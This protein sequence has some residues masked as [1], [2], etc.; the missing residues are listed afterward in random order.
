[1]GRRPSVTGE[2]LRKAEFRGK[3]VTQKNRGVN[4]HVLCDLRLQTG[5]GG[6]SG[7]LWRGG[8]KHFHH[9]KFCLS[10]GS[11]RPI[12]GR[13]VELGMVI[14]DTGGSLL[15][16]EE[17]QR[18]VYDHARVGCDVHVPAAT[19]RLGCRCEN[20]KKGKQL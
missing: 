19:A 3:G 18:V 20:E 12:A 15:F 10:S 1:M 6:E 11:R 13:V 9:K 2:G 17:A 14:L 8:I 5:R 7:G 16:L 4:E